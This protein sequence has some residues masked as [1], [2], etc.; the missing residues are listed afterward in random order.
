MTAAIVAARI[1]PASEIPPPRGA[2]SLLIALPGG[3]LV[4]QMAPAAFAHPGD[5]VHVVAHIGSS[6]VSEWVEI[7]DVLITATDSHS[8]ALS[9]LHR[10]PGCDVVMAGQVI[11]VRDGTQVTVTGPCPWPAPAACASLVHCWLTTGQPVTTLH[12]AVLIG[13]GLVAILAVHTPVTQNRAD[14]E[15]G[16]HAEVIPATPHTRPMPAPNVPGQIQPHRSARRLGPVPPKHAL[17]HM[18]SPHHGKS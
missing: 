7:G 15:H 5:D 6:N 12:E 1:K 13:Y 3:E 2:R 17:P 11:T 9:L 14:P 4:F 18:A 8:P 10:Y 16:G